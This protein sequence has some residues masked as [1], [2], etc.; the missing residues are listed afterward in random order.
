VEAIAHFFSDPV[1]TGASRAALSVVFLVGGWQKLRDPVVFRG[2]VEN[3]GLVP[4]ALVPLVAL[5]LP[6]VEL[7]CGAF[8]LV[9][10]ASSLAALASLLL[11][12]AV[13]GAVALSL[14]RGLAGI[15]CGCGGLSSQPLTWSLVLRNAALIA[16]A[17]VAMQADSGRVLGWL[18]FFLIAMTALALL[19]LYVFFNQLMSNEPLAIRTRNY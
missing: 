8:L 1:V 14:L 10:E 2:A 18:D 4:A 3:Y 11:M 7:L 15:D 16:L 13:T 12:L 6:L 9:P 5:V 17:Y 19:G